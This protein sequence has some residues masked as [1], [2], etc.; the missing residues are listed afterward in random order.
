[1]HF[2]KEVAEAVVALLLAL[3]IIFDG[4]LDFA[5]EHT[6][7]KHIDQDVASTLIQA[8]FYAHD[9]ERLS[10]LT[11]PLDLLENTDDFSLSRFN[12]TAKEV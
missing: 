3:H 4:K 9:F 2:I 10:T 1:M 6:T 11:N 7:E 12:L 8:I 5:K